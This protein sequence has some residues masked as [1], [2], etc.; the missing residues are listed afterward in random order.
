MKNYL[1]STKIKGDIIYEIL[2]KQKIKL[3]KKIS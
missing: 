1:N 2:Q 3:M